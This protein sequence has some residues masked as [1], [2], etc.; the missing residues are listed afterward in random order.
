MKRRMY[1]RTYIHETQQQQP[2]CDI[3]DSFS[4]FSGYLFPMPSREKTPTFVRRGERER[5]NHLLASWY[6][7][8]MSLI[9]STLSRPYDGDSTRGPTKDRPP[10]TSS[11]FSCP[12]LPCPALLSLPS[13]P[14]VVLPYCRI[15]VYIVKFSK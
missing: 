10:P 9:S 3:W 4:L 8:P 5:L 7:F 13:V 6:H 14:F 15:I 11:S 12:A 1:V 2:A